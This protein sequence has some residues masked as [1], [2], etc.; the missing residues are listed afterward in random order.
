M[1]YMTVA[2]PGFYQE[3]DHQ[4]PRCGDAAKTKMELLHLQILSNI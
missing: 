3:Y 4:F 1:Q 2:F